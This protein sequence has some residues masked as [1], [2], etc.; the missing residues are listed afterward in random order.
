MRWI[1]II[2]VLLA[3]FAGGVYL[4]YGTIEPC[5]VLRA[6]MRHQT[7]RDGGNFGG[8]IAAMVPDSVINGMITEEYDK[9]VTPLLCIGALIG[10][11]KPAPQGD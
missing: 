7:A 3:F 4:N 2:V 9:P 10:T 5:G 8:M 6:K 1:T 11:E